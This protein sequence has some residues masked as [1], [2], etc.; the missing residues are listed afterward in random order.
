[1]KGPGVGFAIVLS[2][3]LAFGVAAPAAAR[4]S[5]WTFK[6]GAQYEVKPKLPEED[7]WAF[8]MA[9]VNEYNFAGPV[10]FEFGTGIAVN[11]TYFDWNFEAGLLGKFPIGKVVVPTFH[12]AV[13]FDWREFFEAQSGST[14]TAN[15]ILGAIFGPGVRFTFGEAERAVLI[16]LGFVGGKLLRQPKEAYF[17]ILPTL[18]F[19]F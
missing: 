15:F 12:A 14:S 8:A 19:Q 1:M 17:A 13:I 10:W 7:A 5:A 4:S 2:T 11:G 6:P 3:C 18:G 16:E 9:F